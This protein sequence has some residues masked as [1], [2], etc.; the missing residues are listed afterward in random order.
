MYDKLPTLRKI[1]SERKI[2]NSNSNFVTRSSLH[3]SP[4]NFEQ[5]TKEEKDQILKI[6]NEEEGYELK[7]LYYEY[8]SIKNKFGNG[9]PQLDNLS[10]QIRSIISRK[11]NSDSSKSNNL[12][13]ILTHLK[14]KYDFEKFHYVELFIYFF[15]YVTFNEKDLTYTFE[16][17]SFIESNKSLFSIIRKENT[18]VVIDQEEIER[19]VL[20]D[21]FNYL[22]N[23]K[24]LVTLESV[25]NLLNKLTCNELSEN[26]LFKILDKSDKGFVSE[27]DLVNLLNAIT[28]FILNNDEPNILNL[29]IDELDSKKQIAI[30]KMFKNSKTS[31]DFRQVK[32]ICKL[33]LLKIILFFF[34]QAEILINYKLNQANMRR[35]STVSD[36][37][38]NIIDDD[39]DSLPDDMDDNDSHYKNKFIIDEEGDLENEFSPD[40][41]KDNSN[42]HQDNFS[43]DE[44]EK[45]FKAITVPK[46]NE[47][48]ELN[49][50]EETLRNIKNLKFLSTERTF[51]SNIENTIQIKSPQAF[52]N[53]DDKSEQTP[54]LFTTIQERKDSEKNSLIN[55]SKHKNQ[56]PTQYYEEDNQL[57]LKRISFGEINTINHYQIENKKEESFNSNSSSEDTNSC[58][59]EN[60]EP[61]P[62]SNFARSTFK[63]SSLKQS[64]KDEKDNVEIL[65]ETEIYIKEKIFEKIEILKIKSCLY[66]VSV[67]EMIFELIKHD[68]LKNICKVSCLDL[69]LNIVNKYTTPL[70]IFTKR[71]AIVYILGFIFGNERNEIDFFELIGSM[72]ILTKGEYN[73]KIRILFDIISNIKNNEELTILKQKEKIIFTISGMVCVFL[74]SKNIH[75]YSYIMAESIYDKIFNKNHG[76]FTMDNF[77]NWL[78]FNEETVVKCDNIIIECEDEENDKMSRNNSAY[79]PNE[80]DNEV[81]SSKS[82]ITEEQIYE[83]IF[84]NLG[85]IRNVL[86]FKNIELPEIIE[87]FKKN[88]L[89]GQINKSQYISSIYELLNLIESRQTKLTDDD[90]QK[91]I[92]YFLSFLNFDQ[93]NVDL[94]DLSETLIPLILILNGNLEDK[95]NCIYSLFEDGTGE[96]SINEIHLIFSI[97]YTFI[98]KINPMINY[99]NNIIGK[100]SEMITKDIVESFNLS[101]GLISVKIL[102]EYYH[103]LI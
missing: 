37:I 27:D 75:T 48:D 8:K 43:E 90:K 24:N 38:I 10:K 96:L 67:Y 54:K 69:I 18:I 21:L 97:I 79:I 12:N 101:N 57:L 50:G 19:K 34:E 9:N 94:F 65:N 47:E 92:A 85:I 78:K 87:I 66:D 39:I 59:I 51:E 25:I 2:V 73:E 81:S 31:L 83:L 71:Q 60:E 5:F 7:E 22:K 58:K 99:P 77:I 100:L 102:V 4:F 11:Y 1:N 53:C 3:I 61:I 72:I 89:L 70:N 6:I 33:D 45:Y 76:N 52:Q 64:V 82:N 20:K 46:N 30:K 15:D 14:N 16:K 29:T 49:I 63:K 40:N 42:Q 80:V 23:E 62:S 28:D 26:N 44:D 35:F 68:S 56:L 88:T 74:N 13:I 55:S 98:F 36:D 86:N 84:K 93:K 103:N 32:N 91:K 95:L 17:N 41:N